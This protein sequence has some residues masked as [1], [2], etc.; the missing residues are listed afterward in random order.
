MNPSAA[1]RAAA[2]LGIDHEA[3]GKDIFSPPRSA[4]VR[5]SNLY[6]SPL[7]AL[8]SSSPTTS[9]STS[10]TSSLFLAN[11]GGNRSVFLDAF[12]TGL[13]EQAFNALVMLVNRALIPQSSSHKGRSRIHVVDTPGFQHRELA[14][15]QD[16][17]SFDDLCMNY[18]QERLQMLFHDSTF[19]SE[20]DRYL[21][22]EINWMF[23]EMA[24]SPLSLIDTI[25][26]HVPQVRLISSVS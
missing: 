13:Y 10:I 19:T 4:T 26:K 8:T 11:L 17:A 23:S 22:E 25:D 9:D 6:N 3:L 18:A 15:A 21:Q 24:A 7:G 1:Q 5:I 12:V 2:I 14:G 16:G 20:Q